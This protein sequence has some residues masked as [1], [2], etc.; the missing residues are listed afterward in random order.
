QADEEVILDNDTLVRLAH[1]CN[2]P[3]ELG[4]AWTGHFKDY[5]V[6]PLFEQFGRA[7]YHLPEEKKKETQIKDFEGYQITTFKLRGKATKVGYLRGDSGDGGWFHVYR[8][9]FP[10]LGI[11]AVLEFTGSSLP[12]EDRSAALEGLSFT[13]LKG[14]REEVYSWAPSQLPLGKVPP[15]LLSEVYNDVKQVAAE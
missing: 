7:T 3:A 6:T 1:T 4:A 2:T 13:N 9:P 5:D 10:S 15:V 12:E 14:E 11:Q 8:K